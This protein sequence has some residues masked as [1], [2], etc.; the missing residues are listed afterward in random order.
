MFQEINITDL[1]LGGNLNT[2]GGNVTVDK[3]TKV[4]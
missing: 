3:K 2:F 1:K 4:A